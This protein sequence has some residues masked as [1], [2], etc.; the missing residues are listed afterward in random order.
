MKKKNNLNISR[1]NMFSIVPDCSFVFFYIFELQFGSDYQ[2]QIEAHIYR[3]KTN[4]KSCT[5][6]K[7][8]YLV[9]YFGP[10]T[11]GLCKPYRAHIKIQCYN[12]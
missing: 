10:D 3:K 2:S 7:L 8:L 6:E 11:I 5:T 1:Y 4:E 12:L 9:W